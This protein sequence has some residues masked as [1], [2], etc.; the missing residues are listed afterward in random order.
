M[1]W[2]GFF[3]FVSQFWGYSW[4]IM[5]CLKVTYVSSSVMVL[6]TVRQLEREPEGQ[7]CVS[8]HCWVQRDNWWS[9]VGVN[10]CRSTL[11]CSEVV[12]EIVTYSFPQWQHK[13]QKIGCPLLAEVAVRSP[14]AEMVLPGFSKQV[15]R[16]RQ[17][18][19][20]PVGGPGH[21]RRSEQIY[22]K[23][24]SPLPNLYVNSLVGSELESTFPHKGVKSA[25]PMPW[26]E[27]NFS[28]PVMWLTR[29]MLLSGPQKL[30]DDFYIL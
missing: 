14:C 17:G 12:L 29:V 8:H 19:S 20:C 16:W 25:L 18:L 1:F 26:A 7:V 30:A 23:M 4:K 21:A 22:V 15:L 27:N 6:L 11:T 9:C 5:Y 13:I 24:L 3:V 2:F 10:I 28:V